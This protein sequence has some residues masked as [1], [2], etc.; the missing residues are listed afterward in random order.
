MANPRKSGWSFPSVQSNV[1][2][3]HPELQYA[4][5]SVAD[6]GAPHF[7]IY[8]WE[9]VAVS[10]RSSDN[11]PLW[12]HLHQNAFLDKRHHA[13]FLQKKLIPKSQPICASIPSR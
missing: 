7:A 11:R 13:L 4:F 12:P 3:T 1:R 9:E 5:I 6:I 10:G 2:N 8:A